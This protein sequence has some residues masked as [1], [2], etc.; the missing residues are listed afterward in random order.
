MPLAAFLSQPTR[1][2]HHPHESV[3]FRLGMNWFYGNAF[4]LGSQFLQGVSD[5]CLAHFLTTLGSG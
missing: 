4:I 2:C 5:L 1:F 3:L